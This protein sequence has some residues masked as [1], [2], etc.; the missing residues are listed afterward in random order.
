MKR[1]QSKKGFSVGAVIAVVVGLIMILAVAVPIA[2]DLVSNANLTG[3]NALI[4]GVITTLLL[5]GTIVLVTRLYS[6]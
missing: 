1:L 4:A 3:T 5:V 6:A 2:A